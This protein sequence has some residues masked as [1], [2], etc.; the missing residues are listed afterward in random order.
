[1][2]ILAVGLVRQRQTL[3]NIVPIVYRA[4]N[5]ATLPSCLADLRKAPTHIQKLHE[6]AS[7]L[8]I[9]ALHDAPSVAYVLSKDG[10][11]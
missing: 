7:P 5:P 9:A 6:T 11:C 1:M 4:P 10:L 8:K 3:P 2:L